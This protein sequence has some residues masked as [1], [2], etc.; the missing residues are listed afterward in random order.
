MKAYGEVQVLLHPFLTYGM[1]GGDVSLLSWLLVHQVNQLCLAVWRK[2]VQDVV[3]STGFDL[4]VREYS[5]WLNYPDLFQPV[6]VN[7]DI[8]SLF[9]GTISI[10]VWEDL[11][12]SQT[13][14]MRDIIWQHGRYWSRQHSKCMSRAMLLQQLPLCFYPTRV[15]IVFTGRLKITALVKKNTHRKRNSRNLETYSVVCPSP[16]R[17]RRRFGGCRRLLV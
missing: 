3:L 8:G 6:L 15:Y 5:Q 17:A 9:R 10:F 16:V 11:Q 7:V 1:H 14:L 12:K 13:K 2:F 4:S